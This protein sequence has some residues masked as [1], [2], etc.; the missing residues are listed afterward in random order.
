MAA[1]LKANSRIPSLPPT[2]KS[3]AREAPVL[4]GFWGLG[5]GFWDLKYSYILLVP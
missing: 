3:I 2:L 5:F 4:I 1:E